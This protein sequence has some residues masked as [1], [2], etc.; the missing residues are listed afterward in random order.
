MFQIRVFSTSMIFNVNGRH[1]SLFKRPYCSPDIGRVEKT[2]LGIGNHRH[3]DGATDRLGMTGQFL[4]RQHA[5]VGKSESGCG[6]CIAANVDCRV[7]CRLDEHGAQ[8]I[9][10]PRYH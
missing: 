5:D 4:E 10:G 3:A 6:C 8:G 2:A 7:T 1:A 9:I